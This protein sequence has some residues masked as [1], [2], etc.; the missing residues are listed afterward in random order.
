MFVFVEEAVAEIVPAVVAA[1]A[2]DWAAMHSAFAE[3]VHALVDLA[4]VVVD[5]Q[6]GM[7][8]CAAL[9]AA[10]VLEIDGLALV[11]LPLLQQEQRVVVMKQR[12]AVQALI[13]QASD[14]YL[15]LVRVAATLMLL[16]LL[17]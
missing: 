6:G 11:W 1:A 2:A 16:L 17:Q 13:V 9:S 12:G 5:A 8:G 7:V 4:D 10:I 3:A 15:V 14:C